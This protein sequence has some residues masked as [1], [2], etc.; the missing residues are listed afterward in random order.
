MASIVSGLCGVVLFGLFYGMNVFVRDAVAVLMLVSVLAVCS[1]LSE[2]FSVDRK[3]VWA[4]TYPIFILSWP[5]QLIVEV[6]LERVMH[7]P[8]F[9]VMPAMIAAGILGPLA[10]LTI[11]DGVP[12][13][14]NNRLFFSR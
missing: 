5:C 2:R 3:S 7:Q 13:L 8:W 4:R 9:A 11:C 14:R 10:V 6:V 1:A 12:M